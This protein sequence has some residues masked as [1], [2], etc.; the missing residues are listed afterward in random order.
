M[1]CLVRYCLGVLLA[2]LWTVPLN[3]QG[4]EGTIRGTVTDQ[5]QSPVAGVTL[6]IGVRTGVTQADGSYRI[7]GVPA[8]S[9]T[10]RARMIGYT[11]AARLVTVSAGQTVNVDFT[12]TASAVNLAEL[13][14]VGYGEQAAGNITGAVTSLTPEEFNTGRVVTPTELIQNKV[15]GVQ[16]VESNEPGGGTS[17]RI[18]GTTSI[19]ASSEPLIVMDG[20]P[21]ASGSG[22]GIS[23][24]RDPLNFL[25]PDDIASITVL[26]DASAAAIYG[27]NAANGVILIQTKSGRG[28]TKPQIEYSGSLSASS[29][30]RLPTMLSATQFA[31]AVAQFAPSKVPQLG[32]AN[33]DWLSLVDRTSFGQEHNLAVSGVG[34]NSNYRLSANFLDQDGILQ[35]TTTQRISLGANYTQLLFSDRLNLQVNLRGSR[36]KDNFTPGGVL[37]GAVAMASTQPVHDTATA[38]GFYDWPFYPAP[39]NPVAVLEL[40][41][42]KSTTFRGIG[43]LQAGYSLPFVTGLRANVNVGFDVTKADRQTFFPSV[44]LSQTQTDHGNLFRSNPTQVNS[45]ITTYLN[46]VAPRNLGP[47][48]LDLTGG[49][50]F[51]KS[52]GEFPSL[53]AKGLATD[54]LETGGIPAADILQNDLAVDDSRLISLFGRATYNINDRYLVAMSIRRDGS[55]RFGD[56]NAWG[57]FPSAAVAWRI[58]QEPF[59]QGFNK[60]SDLKLRASWARTGNQSFGNY[61]QFSTYQLSDAQ[62]QYQF[63]DSLVT[64]ARP[65]A[66]DR[67][68][69]WEATRSIDFG[70]DY[71]FGNQRFTGSIDWYDKK[72]TDL[73]FTVPVAAGTNLSNFVTSNIGS[74]RNRGIE[75]SLSARVLQGGGDGLSWTA[76]VTAAHNTNELLTINPAAGGTTQILVGGIGGGVGNNIQ[77]LTPGEP[78]NSFFVYEHIRDANGKPIYADVNGDG[79]ITDQDLYKDLNGDGNITASDRRAFHDPAPKWILGHSS[80]FGYRSFDFGFTLR[81]Y[82]GNYVYNNVASDLGH[83]RQLTSSGSPFNLHTSVLETGFETPQLFSDFYVEKASFLRMDN[84]TVGYSFNYR[85]VP[86]RVFATVQNVFTATGYSGVDPTAGLNGIDNNIYPRS[87]TYS[88]GLTFRF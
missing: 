8:G 82:L 17:I 26:R 80:Y 48:A 63:G 69:R 62:S 73:I 37:F 30:T 56:D 57:T 16:V 27:A 6:Q 1:R 33:T 28:T 84:L 54:L 11:P 14:V 7:S 61:L 38:T 44:L 22:G 32:T 3:A 50:S 5:A 21:L 70:I 55:S 74:M 86:A 52:H 75:F 76:D 42:D 2:A 64:T 4:S 12:L 67:T 29:V 41:Q 39:G 15:A 65:S 18:R 40:A 87:R 59:M 71:G 10:L 35:A 51:S 83:Y 78:V 79:S 58:S 25:N 49:Y 20:M 68:I 43:N 45:V 24:G 31:A 46:Y 66:V 77:V 53:T 34:E 81:A 13:V 23:G 9:D 47:G 85:S 72:T 88:G 19:N 60:L 36:A